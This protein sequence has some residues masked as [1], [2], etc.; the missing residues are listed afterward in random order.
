[1]SSKGAEIARRYRERCD[2]DSDR[3]RNYLEKERDKW[4]ED[5]ETEMKKGVSELSEREEGKK[6]EMESQARAKNREGALRQ[7]NTTQLPCSS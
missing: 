6:K 1:M 4:N 2:A 3:I 5:R 7:S